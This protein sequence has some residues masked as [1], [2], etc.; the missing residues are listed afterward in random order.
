[1]VDQEPVDERQAKVLRGRRLVVAGGA[2]FVLSALFFLIFAALGNRPA[3]SSMF[4]PGKEYIRTT[5]PSGSP[6]VSASTNAID[7]PA[8]G[9]ARPGEASPSA[10]GFAPGPGHLPPEGPAT[11]MPPAV[12]PPPRWTAPPP[13]AEQQPTSAP[14][15]SAGASSTPTTIGQIASLVTAVTGLITAIGGLLAIVL[16]RGATHK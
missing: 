5:P 8:D 2:L 11:V 13:R 3:T 6:T 1:M 14:S 4:S 15:S 9:P 10:P 12:I 7:P 16:T